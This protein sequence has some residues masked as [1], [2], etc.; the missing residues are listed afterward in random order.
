MLLV[1]ALAVSGCG[2]EESASPIR[3]GVNP[4]VG[5]EALHLA[6]EKG[7]FEELGVA[8]DLVEYSSLGDVRRALERGNID[9]MASTVIEVLEARGHAPVSP[10]IIMVTD[11]SDEA[12]T[13]MGRLQGISVEEFTEARAGVRF[14]S[15]SDMRPILR[16]SLPAA[17]AE[18][19]KP[20]RDSPLLSGSTERDP[21]CDASPL[22]HALNRTS[23]LALRE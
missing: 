2:T 17:V 3:L 23:R 4:W 6:R 7:H 15:S 10:T 14:V 9:A 1:C 21:Y 22:E 16:E 13:I 12:N 8:V 19:E 5:Y 18:I 20:L 11:Y